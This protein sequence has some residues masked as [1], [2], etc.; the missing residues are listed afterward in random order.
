M[1]LF[2]YTLISCL[3]GALLLAETCTAS[4]CETKET[5]VFYGNG[6]KSLKKNAYDSRKII[7][8]RLKAALPPEEF[9]I[10]EFDVS[11]ND[12]H[13]LPLD[14]LESSIQ[15]LTGIHQQFY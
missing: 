4:I 9:E 2:I 3:F 10:L 15:M 7:M 11:Y 14:L 5:V 8:Q 1:K 6:V 13:G 12:S